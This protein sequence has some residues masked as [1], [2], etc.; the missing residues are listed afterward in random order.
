MSTTIDRH[1]HDRNAPQISPTKVLDQS[2]DQSTTGAAAPAADEPEILD[3]VIVDED[4]A[5]AG[6]FDAPAPTVEA[7]KPEPKRRSGRGKRKLNAPLVTRHTFAEPTRHVEP[8]E[9]IRLIMGLWVETYQARGVD[10]AG[11][12]RGQA[13]AE[14][15]ALIDVGN[16]PNLVAAAA[17]RAAQAGYATVIREV[18]RMVNTAQPPARRGGSD[19]LANLAPGDQIQ[20]RTEFLKSRPNWERLARYGI[21][22]DNAALYGFRAS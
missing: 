9:A 18:E 16:N 1:V 4:D 5:T 11:T 22:P 21:T 14:I 7:T 6:L 17:R 15:A 20:V 2:G 13:A 12:T 3:A 8:G 10:P 19:P